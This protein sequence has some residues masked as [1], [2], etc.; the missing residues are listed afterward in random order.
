MDLK[1]IGS[2]PINRP[3]YLN[4]NYIKK[5]TFFYEAFVWKYSV[6]TINNLDMQYIDKS[7][8]LL[9]INYTLTLSKLLDVFRLATGNENDVS[10]IW[11]WYYVYYINFLFV[12]NLTPSNFDLFEKYNIIATNFK[13]KQFRLSIIASNNNIY[14]L[15]VG[16]V[17]ASLNIKE[18]SKKKSDKGERLFVEFLLNFFKKNNLKFGLN[19]YAIFKIT[20]LKKK[21]SIRDSILKVL[22]KNFNIIAVINNFST[23]NN[24]SKFKKVRSIKRRLKKRIVKNEK[25]VI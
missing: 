10:N 25:Y 7:S 16:R 21:Y 5:N 6:D 24:Y 8:N 23:P 3:I 22:N 17:L 4:K 2:N 18:K 20:G 13:S 11:N 12:K 14:N 19:R 15:T 9:G 1:V